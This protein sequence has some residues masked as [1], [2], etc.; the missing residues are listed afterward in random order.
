MLCGSR[1]PNSG[2]FYALPEGSLPKPPRRN[3][4]PHRQDGRLGLERSPDGGLAAFI[5]AGQLG[6]G[7][8]PGVALCDASAL[9]GVQGG[10]PA[11]LGALVELIFVQPLVIFAACR[12]H[13]WTLLFD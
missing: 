6:H 8:A 11:E 1:Y 12:G 13:P 10:E 5:L 4:G 7:L 9:A 3:F 2:I